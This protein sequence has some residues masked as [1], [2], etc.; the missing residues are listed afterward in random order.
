MLSYLSLLLLLSWAGFCA[1]ED[2]RYKRIDNRLVLVGAVMAILH[3]L[4]WQQSITAARPVDVLLAS[5]LALLFT[6]P[7]YLTGR[8]GAGDVKLLVVL[9]LASDSLFLLFSLAGA[10]LGIVLW[11][12]LAPAL[13]PRLPSA[14]QAAMPMLAPPSKVLPYAPFVFFG[15]LLALLFGRSLAW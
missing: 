3:L 5:G 6:L 12:L 2:A 9:A 8:I 15:M 1:V 14:L 10:T 7:G 4:V 13:W 11:L